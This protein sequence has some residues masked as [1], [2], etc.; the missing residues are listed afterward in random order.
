MNAETLLREKAVLDLL[1]AAA[2]APAQVDSY[3]ERAT[4]KAFWRDLNPELSLG[5][6][7]CRWFPRIESA[8]TG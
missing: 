5:S 2:L 1:Q 6:S 3:F 7:R 8:G 4:D